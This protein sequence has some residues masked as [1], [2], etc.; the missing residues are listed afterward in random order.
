MI[1]ALISI[2][3]VGLIAGLV[4]RTILSGPNNPQVFIKTT[5][6]GILGAFLATAIGYLVGWSNQ[7]AGWIASIIGAI[8]V[9]A[10]WN[11]WELGRLARR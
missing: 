10:I 11:R 2:I 1:S 7:V 8:I 3:V 9:L 6:L 5:A 4:A